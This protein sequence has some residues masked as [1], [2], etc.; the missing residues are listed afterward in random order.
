MLMWHPCQTQDDATSSWQQM[1]DA[2]RS[3]AIDSNPAALEAPQRRRNA[4]VRLG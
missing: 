4:T 3:V 2:I 1:S